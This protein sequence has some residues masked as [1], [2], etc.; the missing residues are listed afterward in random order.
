M[1]HRETYRQLPDAAFDLCVVG[2]A[3]PL[4]FLISTAGAQRWLNLMVQSLV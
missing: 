2:P 3:E 1:A 4:F